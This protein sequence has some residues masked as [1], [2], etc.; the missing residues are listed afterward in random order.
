MTNTTF[1]NN[2]AMTMDA[3][4][5]YLDCDEAALYMCVYN[6]T[7]SNFTKNNASVNGGAIKYTFY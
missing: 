6:I 3:G 2:T 1:Y 7:N 4:A 5:L